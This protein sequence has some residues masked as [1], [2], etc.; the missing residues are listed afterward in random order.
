MKSGNLLY[1]AAQ[2]FFSVLIL[3]LGAVL[4]GLEYA[5][6]LRAQIA[7]FFLSSSHSFAF[8]GCVVLGC[9]LL[10][11]IGFSRMHRG[12]YY[13]LAMGEKKTIVEHAV[14]QGYVAASLR[15]LFPEQELHVDVSIAANGKIEVFAELPPLSLEE[16]Q[17]L[18][19]KVEKELAT[20]FKKQLVYSKDF[21]FSVVF[22]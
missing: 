18:L 4:I 3:L 7:H 10:L 1:S 12:I 2:F 21:S 22:K 13:T 6:H 15:E 17:G 16:Q 5:P 20:L 8:L 14:I 19:E 9:G 11:L